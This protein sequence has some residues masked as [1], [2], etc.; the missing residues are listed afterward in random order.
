MRNCQ[1]THSMTK[2]E[3]PSCS[4]NVQVA[5]IFTS[6]LKILMEETKINDTKFVHMPSLS[7]VR[8]RSCPDNP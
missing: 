8:L 7:L 5:S 3:R 4:T 1:E 6:T 2:R